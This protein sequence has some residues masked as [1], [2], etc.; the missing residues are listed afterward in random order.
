MVFRQH[1]HD[2]HVLVILSEA[3]YGVHEHRQ[4][5]D[6]H[7]LL[8]RVATHAQSLAAS[9]YHNMI[10]TRRYLPMRWLYIMPS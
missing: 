5:A 3:P 4:S 7:K 1:Q 6:R 8:G 10:H 2:V 9:H